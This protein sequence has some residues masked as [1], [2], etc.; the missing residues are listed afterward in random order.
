MSLPPK[1]SVC[2]G[3]AEVTGLSQSHSAQ[4]STGEDTCAGLRRHGLK[5]PSDLQS[6][7]ERQE[8]AAPLITLSSLRIGM[9]LSGQGREG[10][11]SRWVVGRW[12]EKAKS[13]LPV[14][15]HYFFPECPRQCGMTS[16]DESSP[17]YFRQIRPFDATAC[18]G[19]K[20]TPCCLPKLLS[21]VGWR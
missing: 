11:W 18:W 1:S 6:G 20:E 15:N 14:E 19:S 16:E 3:Q 12:G 4:Q 21:V 9:V 7:Q 2:P 5:A 8:G 10:P 17:S 13:K